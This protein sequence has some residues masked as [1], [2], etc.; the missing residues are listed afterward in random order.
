MTG[1]IGSTTP[2]ASA[3]IAGGLRIRT[4][5]INANGRIVGEKIA[6]AP[7][8]SPVANAARGRPFTRNSNHKASRFQNT[9]Q[10]AGKS[11]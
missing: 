10:V 3:A 2:S 1:A 4:A 8:A 5:A 7:I 11:S 6:E 9:I